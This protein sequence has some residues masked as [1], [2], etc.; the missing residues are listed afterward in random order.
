MQRNLTLV[1]V[2]ACA[3]VFPGIAAAQPKETPRPGWTFIP[4]MT[5]SGGYDD[6]VLLVG[7]APGTP[8][9]ETKPADY[10]TGLLPGG[11]LDYLGPRLQF[12][13][14]YLG[15]FVLYR[16]LGELNSVDQSARARVQYRATRRTTLF[17][18]QSYS[19]SRT[20][21]TLELVGIP[22]RRIGN[23]TS[24]TQG[25]IEQKLTR[26]TT[27]KAGYD[28]RVVNFDNSFDQFLT[29]PGGH[30]HHMSGS[31]DHLLTQRLTLGGQY[32]LRRVVI[33]NN[34]DIVLV[35]HTAAT[36]E[37]RINEPLTLSGSIGFSHLGGQ[38]PTTD[39]T[40]AAYRVALNGRFEHLE[41]IGA[42]ARSVL[43]SFGF[44]GTFQ[45]EEFSSTV[46]APFARRRGYVQGGFAWRNNNPLLVGPPPTESTWYSS[47][48]GYAVRPWI[49]L[50]GYYTHARQN[51]QR[52]GGIV[53]RNRVGFQIVTSK[54]MALPR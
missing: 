26:R 25:S 28:L 22:F 33:T 43:P 40:G 21:D 51:T 24:V 46:R 31:I 41:V 27:A 20:T 37:Y 17:A 48:L 12:S 4:T 9:V 39:K 10:V 35:H 47:L 50:E 14:G 6:N 45:N 13:T 7:V 2:F 18:G 53:D 42:Y 52:A 38:V 44:G 23:W 16:D 54:R 36:A 34:P 49:R 1:L 29:F 15:S 19:T 3:F 11:A 32:E 8:F 30:E 5:F